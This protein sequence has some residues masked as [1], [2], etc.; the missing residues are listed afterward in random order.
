M[1]SKP[2]SPIL[3]LGLILSFCSYVFL[4]VLD[5]FGWL[6]KDYAFQS[7][8]I[9]LLFSAMLAWALKVDALQ[10]SDLGFKKLSFGTLTWGVLGAVGVFVVMGGYYFLVS[11][12]GNT[13]DIPEMASD[14]ASQSLAVL[15]LLCL[16]ISL[17]EEFLFRAYAITRIH[18]QTG[19]K[20]LA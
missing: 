10:P 18:S 16:S 19:S 1:T 6:T 8:I 11:L 4:S 2:P 12:S 3:W 14:I 9:L 7:V 15:F 17:F 5:H 20:L 13:L